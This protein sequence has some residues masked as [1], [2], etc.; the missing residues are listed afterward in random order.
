MKI[1]RHA[2]LAVALLFVLPIA[3]SLPSKRGGPSHTDVLC[4]AVS[5]PLSLSPGHRES[6][7]CGGSFPA[8]TTAPGV[9]LVHG[10]SGDG[11]MMSVLARWIARNGHAVLTIDVRGH[12]ANRNP[13]ENGFLR[14]DLRPDVRAAV[15]L[16]ASRIASMAHGSR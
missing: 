6:V 5:R 2:A 7:F 16:S 12:G 15:D 10:F 11:E 14:A 1:L 4:K 8:R 3:V 13:F 9:V